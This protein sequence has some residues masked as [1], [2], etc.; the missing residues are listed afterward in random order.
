[1]RTSQESWNELQ[2]EALAKSGHEFAAY[3]QTRALGTSAEDLS[4]LPIQ[5]IVAGSTYRIGL[6]IGTIDLV[7]EGENKKFDLATAD[8]ETTARFFTMWTGDA[9]RG[10]GIAASIADWIDTD[11]R[12]RY[13]GAE[14]ESYTDRGYLPRNG[15]LGSADLFLIKGITAADL[16]PQIV[17]LNGLPAINRALWH[18]IATSPTGS[19]INI[20]YGSRAMLQSLP[21]MTTELLDSMLQLRREAIFADVQDFVKRTGAPSDSPFLNYLAFDRGAAPAVMSIARL[22][23]SSLLRSERRVR[24]QVRSPQLNRA[25]QNRRTAVQFLTLVERDIQE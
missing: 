9:D 24:T 5:P 18:F 4:G 13:L 11:D 14:S 10:R 1:M 12:P 23:N 22:H 25:Q 21:G 2:A 7:L 19:A 17:Q 6:A 16:G 15:A 20:N 3:L 8:E